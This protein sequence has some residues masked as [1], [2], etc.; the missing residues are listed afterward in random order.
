MTFDSLLV[1]RGLF[2]FLYPGISE[3]DA[4]WY[5]NSLL[6]SR[7][8]KMFEN[9]N[10][11]AKRAGNKRADRRGGGRRGK[12]RGKFGG[13]AHIQKDLNFDQKHRAEDRQ[14]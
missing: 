9:V 3:C 13:S 14:F 4:M 10:K 6:E 7:K 2:L 11:E 8:S 12:T 5:E 1:Y